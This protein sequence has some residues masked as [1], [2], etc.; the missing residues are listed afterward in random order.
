MDKIFQWYW[1]LLFLSL[2]WLVLRLWKKFR[3]KPRIFSKRVKPVDILTVFILYGIHL[4]SLEILHVSML[5]Y[6]FLGM[7]LLG[8]GMTLVY[9][10]IE[11]RLVYREFF[12]H[13]WRFVDIVVFLLYTLLLVLL[14]V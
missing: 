13:Y 1:Q 12:L 5:P 9:V 6:L 2:I 3:L 4:L 11:K 8:I 14:F 7:G 10:F